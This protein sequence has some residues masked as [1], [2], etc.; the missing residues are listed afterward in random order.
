MVVAIH[1]SVLNDLF[2]GNSLALS[3]S[4]ILLNLAV[5]FFFIA[6]GFLCFSRAN[7]N[8]AVEIQRTRKAAHTGLWLYVAWTLIYL[9]ASISMFIVENRL[10]W[11]AIPRYAHKVIFVGEWQ[12]WFLLSMAIGYYGIMFMLSHGF[13]KTHIIFV[14]LVLFVIEC[15]I[16]FMQSACSLF[17]LPVL[18]EKTIS[19]YNVIFA[20]PRVICQGF[21]YISLG[22]LIADIYKK[23]ILRLKDKHIALFVCIVF[24]VLMYIVS[25]IISQATNLF[26]T[27]LIGS[28]CKA[29]LAILIFILTSLAVKQTTLPFAKALR[30]TS[31]VLYLTH[32]YFILIFVYIICRGTSTSL[33]DN[34]FNYVMAFIFSIIGCIIISFIVIPIG[35]KNKLI[36]KLF[37]C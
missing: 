28:L 11:T 21:F 30:S 4:G 25:F 7:G 36:A 29:I 13:S 18:I 32:I 31:A 35:S 37:N 16:E 33:L 23:Y 24:T 27:T 8:S 34:T 14:G 26:I 20:S 22:M 5:P 15:G 6:S 3:L 2:R 10:D 12:L 9:P 19:L 1:T 17:D